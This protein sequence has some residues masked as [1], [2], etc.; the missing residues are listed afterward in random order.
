VLE[1]AAADL[2]DD[3]VY[4][5]ADDLRKRARKLRLDARRCTASA[6]DTS[7]DR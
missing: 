2:E 5:Q 7:P 4:D 1:L 6:A 3:A